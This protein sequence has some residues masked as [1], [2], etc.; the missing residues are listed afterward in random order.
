MTTSV[1][2]EHIDKQEKSHK[3]DNN[4]VVRSLNLKVLPAKIQSSR[5]QKHLGG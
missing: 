2:K 1:Y 4:G 5:D 3:Y